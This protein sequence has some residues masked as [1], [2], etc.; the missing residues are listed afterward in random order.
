MYG[1]LCRSEFSRRKRY[2]RRGGPLVSLAVGNLDGPALTRTP[3]IAEMTVNNGVGCRSS[4]HA[5]EGKM[6]IGVIAT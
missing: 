1:V 4:A 2:F 5:L 3:A 6:G